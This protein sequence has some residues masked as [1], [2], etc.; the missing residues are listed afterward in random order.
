MTNIFERLGI[1]SVVNAS[2]TETPYGAS[3]VRPEVIQAINELIPHSVLMAELQAAASEVVARVMGSEAGCV[4]GCTAAGITIA[5]A[6]CM[7][8]RDLGRVE[9]L[10]DTGGMKN[11][12]VMQRGHEMTYGQNVSQN[13]RIAGAKVVEIGAATQCGAYQLRHAINAQTVAAM[14]VVSPLTVQNRLIDLTTFC[15]TCHEKGVP[16]IVDAASVQDPRPLIAAGADIVIFSAQ[17]SFASITG[18]IIAG[19]LELVQA[20]IYQEHGIGRPMKVGKEGVVGAIAALEAWDKEDR[21][22]AR[23]ALTERLERAKARLER[24][25]G[26]HPTVHG[27]QILLQVD[28]A[29]AGVSAYGLARRLFDHDPVVIVWSQ[30][31]REGQLFLTLGKVTDAMADYVCERIAQI[32]EARE[33]AEDQ[34]PNLGDAIAERLNSWPPQRPSQPTLATVNA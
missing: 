18:G 8:G 7:T 5:V 9:Q 24:I 34:A 22:H 32:C 26:L 10:P 33:G 31:A 23:R 30:F 19:R 6:A 4:T 29:V 3:C 20:C 17:K 11:E 25:A 27:Q 13:V 1:R 14:Y 16:V 28:A 15:Q 12:V 2:G 21:S